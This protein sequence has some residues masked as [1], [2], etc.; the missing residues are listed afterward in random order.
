MKLTLESYGKKYSVETVY[1]DVN[2]TEY[3]D[4][5]KGLLLQVTFTESTIHE[6]IVEMADEFRNE[7]ENRN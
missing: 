6:G 4:F 5:F 7:D 1:E 3:L 2:I